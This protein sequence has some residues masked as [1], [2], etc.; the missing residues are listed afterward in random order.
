MPTELGSNDGALSSFKGDIIADTD[1][2]L[3][4]TQSTGGQSYALGS[5]LSAGIYTM[6]QN[7]T[8]AAGP[9]DP[10]S[11]VSEPDNPL[12][13]F[14]L[15]SNYTSGPQITVSVVEDATVSSGRK[16]TFNIPSGVA[17]GQYLRVYRFVAVPGSKARTATYQARVAWDNATSTTEASVQSISQY[18]QADLATTTGASSGTSVPFTTIAAST[19]AYETSNTPNGTGAI[20]ADGAFI[21]VAF[22]VSVNTL[23]TS[24]FSV[25]CHE[26]RIDRGVIQSVI[27][28]QSLPEQFGYGVIYLF[29][30]TLFIKPNELG[31]TGSSPR[32]YLQASQ[33]NIGI[34]ASQSGR[35]IAISSASRTGSTVTVTTATIHGVN[36]SNWITIAGLSGAAGTT[37]NGVWKITVT[38]TTQFTFTATGTAG[39]A[40]VTGA[41]ATA[42][43]AAGNVSIFPANYGKVFVEQGGLDINGTIEA[44]KNYGTSGLHRG[45]S[46]VR[47]NALSIAS[48]IPV[49]PTTANTTAITWQS[50]LKGD[51]EAVVATVS[52]ARG[53]GTTVTYTLN[54]AAPGVGAV[55]NITGITPVAYNLSAATVVSRDAHK[56]TV[57]NAAT[58]TYVSGGSVAIVSMWG[59]GAN[60]TIPVTGAYAIS[61]S[62][63]FGTGT[64]YA[65]EC[66][67]FVNSTL[68]LS[69]SHTAST[70][71]TYDHFQ[72][73]GILYLD[74]GDVLTF[75][76]AASTS[77]KSLQVAERLTIG[78]VVLIGAW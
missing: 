29:S 27:T 25:D 2:P 46:L 19:W 57:T 68:R 51:P 76:A 28:D 22:G 16:M 34:D 45:V 17:A 9:P 40:T 74:A 3:I 1:A 20:A 63:Q 31:T 7:G 11:V 14:S 15:E 44:N 67:L 33:G 12:P 78:S 26:V 69:A 41:T 50:T 21:K 55:I 38:S 56:F 42:S 35:P 48:A 39:S 62:S 75:R 53:D 54:G 47:T 49:T 36:T 59:S 66:Y 37:M 43:P 61:F 77:G 32:I 60:I 70:T 8:F 64:G 13:Y 58:G 4:S 23:T 30:G 71:A 18:Y 5:S 72:L 73:Q 65:A 24:A 52:D 6:V 10:D